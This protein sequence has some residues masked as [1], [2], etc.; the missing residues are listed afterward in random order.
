MFQ[1][2]AEN[3]LKVE[4]VNLNLKDI[5]KLWDIGMPDDKRLVVKM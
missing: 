3:K 4:T 1:L 2:T 5:Q